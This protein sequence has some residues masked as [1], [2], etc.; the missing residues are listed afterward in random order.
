M[1]NV[2]DSNAGLRLSKI[3]CLMSVQNCMD[4]STA[5]N[6]FYKI[7]SQARVDG[8]KLCAQRL[9]DPDPNNRYECFDGYCL[10]DLKN[11]PCE[12]QNLA[13]ENGH[14]LNAIIDLLEQY[15]KQLV[16]QNHPTLDPNADPSHFGGYW[17]TW[18]DITPNKEL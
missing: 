7:R 5:E 4:A 2:I 14:I 9:S 18:M 3:N 10:F 13:R 12:Y 17:A 1:L 16:K 15:K 6:L 8:D 11:D